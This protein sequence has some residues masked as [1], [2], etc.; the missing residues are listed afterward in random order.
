M[1]NHSAVFLVVESTSCRSSSVFIVNVRFK[2][3]KAVFEK[4]F[5]ILNQIEVFVD[6]MKRITE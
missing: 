3:E 5:R 1:F 6:V 4:D 2:Y